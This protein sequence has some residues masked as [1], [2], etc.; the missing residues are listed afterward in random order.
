MRELRGRDTISGN[1]GVAYLKYEGENKE[2]FYAKSI[3]AKVSK[4]KSALNPIGYGLK[5]HKSTAR[6][7]GTGTL[8]LYYLSPFFR[9]KIIE[10]K[11]TGQD[12]YFDLV[13]T[14]SDPE[15]E[16]GEQTVLLRDCNVDEVIMTQLDGSAE[17]V[18]EEELP[19]TF[20]DV[21]ILTP[22]KEI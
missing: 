2:L 7:E 15:T 17:D 14:N 1:K 18:L 4:T 16:A 22:F 11:K 8:V 12:V 10:W 13:I 19:F 5:K 21:E 3:T 9:E 20:D 6:G